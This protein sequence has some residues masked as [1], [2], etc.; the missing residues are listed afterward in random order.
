VAAESNAIIS[1]GQLGTIAN[2]FAVFGLG[3][4]VP[5]FGWFTKRKKKVKTVISTSTKQITGP[6]RERIEIYLE[7]QTDQNKAIISSLDKIHKVIEDL[8]SQIKELDKNKI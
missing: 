5:V 3:V 6:V 7:I 1:L 2:I 8:Y 4:A